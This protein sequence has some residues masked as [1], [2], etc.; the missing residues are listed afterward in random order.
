MNHL[1]DFIPMLC[2]KLRKAQHSLE[3]S[4]QG[5]GWKLL[6]PQ[7]YLPFPM[8]PCAP[9][10]KWW[11][12]LITFIHWFKKHL[13]NGF[14]LFLFLFFCLFFLFRAALVACGNSQARGQISAVAAGLCHSHSNVGIQTMSASY[15]TAHGNAGSLTHWARSGT[16]PA[17]S[18]IL[19]RF[20]TTE[21]QQELLV[22]C[23]L[24]ATWLVLSYVLG[25]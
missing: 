12:S 8:G 11:H 15:T 18:W 5:Q 21:L 13:L 20:I 25:I 24:T 23:L 1:E 14:V 19:I 10:I 4:H 22:E 9:L 3:P 2:L 7:T 6:L 16:K 17:C